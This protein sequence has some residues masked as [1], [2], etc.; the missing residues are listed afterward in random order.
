MSFLSGL[1]SS[2]SVIDKTTDALI[3]SGDKLVYTDEE[4]ADMKLKLGEFHIKLLTAYE[5]FKIAQRILA[6]WFSLLFGISFLI[7]LFLAINGKDITA[8][9]ETV[10][11]FSLGTIVLAIVV[12]YFGGG[13]IESFKNIKDKK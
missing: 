3:S 5:P 7:A 12:F 13:T 11:S 9:L 1:F 8:V 10:S 2:T 4:K 6:I